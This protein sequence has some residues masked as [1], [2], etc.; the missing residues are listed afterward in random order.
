VPDL[1]VLW[2]VDFTL[3][4]TRGVGT[5]LYRLAFA[6]LFGRDLPESSTK[7]DM[8]GRTDRA[9][10]L[11]VL[12]L[13]GIPDPPGEVSRFEAAL[14]RLAPG[15]AEMVVASGRALPGANAAIAALAGAGALQSVLTGNVQAMASVKLTPFGL[16]EHLDL[17]IGA[18]GDESAVRADLVHLARDRARRAYGVDF[19]GEATVLVGD[20]PLDVEAALVTGA[21]AVAV[22]T[23]RPSLESLEA[24]GAHAVLADLTD[25]DQVVAAV[26]GLVPRRNY[27]P[28]PA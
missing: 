3:V 25:T 21:R 28:R 15:V 8:G 26:L 18:Y 5:A 23:G 20:T 2:D 24:A 1:L 14:T 22:A 4:D 10:A 12:A 17:D 7:V 6:E 19:S 13:A 9:I 11:D 16:T 27:Q